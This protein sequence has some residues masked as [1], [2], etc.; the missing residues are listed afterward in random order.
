[1][2][3]VNVG[4]DHLQIIES[5]KLFFIDTM[6]GKSWGQLI[7]GDEEFSFLK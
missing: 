7:I 2:I 4:E 6:Y 5:N 3:Q 1:M